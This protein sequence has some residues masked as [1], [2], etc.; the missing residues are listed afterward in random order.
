MEQELARALGLSLHQLQQTGRR[1]DGAV[2]GVLQRGY[3][4]LV[5]LLGRAKA[6]ELTDPTPRDTQDLTTALRNCENELTLTAEQFVDEARAARSTGELRA[7]LGI[8]FAALNHTLAALAPRYRPISHGEAHEEALR[9]FVDLHR[10]D[11]LNRLRW[12]ALEDFDARRPLTDWPELRTLDWITAPSAWALT[13][14]VADTALL[15]AQVEE[16]L[17]VRLG[18]P[19]PATGDSLPPI[20]FVR[21]RNKSVIAG[22]AEDL[23]ALVTASGRT[24]PAALAAPAPEEEIPTW[25][26]AAGALDFRVLGP[27]DVVAWL[28]ALGQWPTDLPRTADLDRHGLT[29]EDLDE[30]RNETNRARAARER[31]RR[32]ISVGNRELDVHSGDFTELNA[33]LREALDA[34]PELVGGHHHFA[35][36]TPLGPRNRGN[37]TGNRPGRTQGRADR[38]LSQ[39][40][41]TAIG[42]AGEWYAYHWLCRQYPGTDESSWVSTNRRGAFPGTPGDDGLGFDFR[43]GSGKQPLMFEI[44]ATQGQGGQIELGES[45]VRAAQQHASHDRWRLLVITSVLD[46]AQL[47]VHMLP[48]PFSAR[49]RGHYREEGGALRFTYHL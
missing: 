21:G 7:A 33:V 17:A 43:V 4:L 20:D 39:A 44:K 10:K 47:Q 46:A 3:P 25:L 30:A 36:I 19:A 12:S 6:D 32:L 15:R 26:E 35:Q 1:I 23:V 14:E 38:G 9:T 5:H 34:R 29:P 24:L 11:L 28:A 16:A 22:R 40:Q 8:D 37:R 48:N 31:A 2:G 49:G 41:R 45:E 27:D 13:V 42:Y 18:A